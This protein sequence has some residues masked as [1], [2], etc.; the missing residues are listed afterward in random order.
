MLVPPSPGASAAEGL[1][2]ADLRVDELVTDIQRDDTLD[3]ERLGDALTEARG[4]ALAQLEAQAFG[5]AESRLDSFLDLRYGG[6]AAELRVPLPAAD[7]AVADGAVR[8]AIAAF[9]RTHEERYGYAYEGEEAVEIVTSA[10]RAR[11]L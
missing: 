8:D 1:L 7:G 3:L 4:R 11:A 5:E 10:S 2:G 6:Q 9:H